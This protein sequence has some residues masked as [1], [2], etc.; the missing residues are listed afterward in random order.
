MNTNLTPYFEYYLKPTYDFIQELL[1]HGSDVEV[2]HPQSLRQ[3]MKG[4]INNMA[5]LYK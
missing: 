4:W 5:E 1:S 3:Q 2:I